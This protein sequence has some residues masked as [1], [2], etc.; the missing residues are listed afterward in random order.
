MFSVIQWAPPAVKV[1]TMSAS[2]HSSE[3]KR[4]PDAFT[5]L[6]GNQRGLTLIQVAK[7]CH[8][9]PSPLNHL[10]TPFPQVGEMPFL[11]VDERLD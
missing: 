9:V 4:K 8:P 1:T 2:R 5:L 7:C 11:S 6:E 10:A 3:I